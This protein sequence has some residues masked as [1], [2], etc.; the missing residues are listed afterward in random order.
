MNSPR[1]NEQKINVCEVPG[2]IRK[3]DSKQRDKKATEHPQW[4][5]LFTL[6]YQGDVVDVIARTLGFRTFQL[7]PY[8]RIKGSS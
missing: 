1:R 2:S 8:S 6:P 3:L 5:R 7:M 4:R